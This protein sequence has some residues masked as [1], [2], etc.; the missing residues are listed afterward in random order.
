[1]PETRLER[2][3]LGGKRQSNEKGELFTLL[4]AGRRGKEI[5]GK[6]RT[7]KKRRIRKALAA[8]HGSYFAK[9]M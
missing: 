8:S 3:E 4:E 6:R 1:M 9:Y 5:E 2:G 7:E